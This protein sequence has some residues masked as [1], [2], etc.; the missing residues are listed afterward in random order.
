MKLS[1]G[2]NLEH[3]LHYYEEFLREIEY[4]KEFR[5]KIYEKVGLKNARRVLEVECRQGIISQELRNETKAQITAIDPDHI[6]IA[7]ASEKIKG[8]EFYR[9]VADKLSMRDDSFDIVFCHYYF[10]WKPKPFGVLMELKRVVK[11]GG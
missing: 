8:I 11:E 7:N 9:E 2:F 10:I 3:P 1:E 4:T 5:K 6:N